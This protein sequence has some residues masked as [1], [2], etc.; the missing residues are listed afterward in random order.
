MSEATYAAV[1]GLVI[2]VAI[3]TL[4]WLY[5]LWAEK[6]TDARRQ[7]ERDARFDLED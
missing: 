7:R 1:S 2:G 4:V 5:Y 3:S 6:R